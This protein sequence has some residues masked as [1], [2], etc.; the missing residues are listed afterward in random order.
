V[1]HFEGCG[2]WQSGS[3]AQVLASTF[4]RAIVEVD[5]W[6]VDK[7]RAVLRRWR[8]GCE[9]PGRICSLERVVGRLDLRIA[10]TRGGAIE[11]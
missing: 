3:L 5:E 8:R 4:W 11:Y 10:S 9:G 1:V 7:A 6:A 2:E